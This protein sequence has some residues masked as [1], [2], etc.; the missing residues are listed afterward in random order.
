M[1]KV[2]LIIVL[3]I[4][5][6]FFSCEKDE[7]KVLF[8]ATAEYCESGKTFLERNYD[9]TGNEYFEIKWEIGDEIQFS[10]IRSYHLPGSME[11]VT[12]IVSSVSQDY[13]TA[14]V[15]ASDENSVDPYFFAGTLISIQT[16]YTLHA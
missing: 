10:T 8:T 3:A 7:K 16:L 11:S 15:Y 4:S 13:R 1:K 6:T 9:D 12:F 2:G 14:Y 5:F